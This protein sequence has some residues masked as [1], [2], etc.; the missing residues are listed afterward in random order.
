LS[1]ACPF[2]VT[3]FSF[4][5]VPGVIIGHNHRIAW[6]FTNVGPD[7]QDLFIE[8]INPANP[9]QYEVN[10]AWRDV[11]TLI[12]RIVVKGRVEP[13]PEDPD[14]DLGTYDPATDTTTINLTVRSTRHGPILTDVYGLEELAAEAGLDPAYTYDFAL[15][16]TALEPTSTFRAIF[17]LNRARNFEEFRTALRDFDAPSQNVVYA[18][19]EGNIGYQMPGNIPMRRNGDGLLPVPGW[20]DEYAWSGYIPFSELPRAYNPPQGYI[21]TAN[22][23]V[24]GPD[25]PHLLS[26]DWDPGYRAQR[27]VEMI[28]A[29]PRLSIADVQQIQGDDL[30]LGAKE[31]LPYLLALDIDEAELREAAEQLRGWD[32]QMRMGSQPAAIYAAFFNALL[33]GTFRDE[34]P[35]DYWPGGGGT[36]WLI[37]RG[38]LAEPNNAWWDNTSTPA[39]ETRDDILRQALAD[40]YAALAETLGA[41]PEIWTWGALHTSTFVHQT[42]GRSGLA[43]IEALFNRGPFATSGGSS[44]VNATGFNLADGDYTVRSLPSMRMIVDLGDLESALTIHTTGQSGHAFHRH[45]DDLIDRW[46]FIQYHPMLWDPEDVE[47]QAEAHLVL[48][49]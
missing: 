17:N 24:V 31:T 32:A 18:D 23:A 22:N 41:N 13:D 40:G 33:A 38:L 15:R 48:T 47:A 29:R 39:V 5:G 42:L 35:E 25:Y 3:G 34:L 9:N 30:D 11:E 8:R 19:V 36:S 1:A 37:L 12:E 46:R 28:E 16:W 45:Y 49:P 10:G 14:Q 21:V 4:A 43:P 44:I 2:D 7:V 20:T 27:I 26:L 6:G